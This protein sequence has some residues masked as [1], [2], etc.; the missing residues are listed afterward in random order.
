MNTSKKMRVG[1]SP[2]VSPARTGHSSRMARPND[3]AESEDLSGV[4]ASDGTHSRR[5]E[6][7][8]N[9]HLHKNRGWGSRTCR[10]AFPNRNAQFALR[11]A[12]MRMRG[13]YVIVFGL[14]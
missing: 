12:R 9:E 6:A 2:C 3:Q 8:Q 10:R 4:N 14:P 5:K 11:L 1:V 13:P 7:T